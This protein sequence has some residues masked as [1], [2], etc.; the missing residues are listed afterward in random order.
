MKKIPDN[1]LPNH[2][3]KFHIDFKNEYQ[4]ELFNTINDPKNKLIF[5]GGGAG[6]GK[7]FIAVAAATKAF[8]EKKTRKIHLCRPYVTALN[9][10]YGYIPGDLSDKLAPILLP[11][12]DQLDNLVGNGLDRKRVEEALIYEAM[13]YL[14][15]RTFNNWVI[16]DEMQNGTFEALTLLTTRIGKYC[17]MIITYDPYQKDVKNSGIEEF[18]ETVDGISG[19][20]NIL[21]PPEAQV[22]EELVQSIINRVEFRRQKLD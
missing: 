2:N 13:G 20:K 6:S 17:K 1:Q 22:R 4:K 7:T 12:Y 14:R 3:N 15:G 16:A 18:V 19:V 21:L 11:I 8:L 9:E 5:I 10:S